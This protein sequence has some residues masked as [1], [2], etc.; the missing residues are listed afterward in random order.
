MKTILFILFLILGCKKQDTTYYSTINTDI[1]SYIQKFESI[2]I[3]QNTNYDLSTIDIALDDLPQATDSTVGTCTYSWPRQIKIKKSFWF[4]HYI[5]DTER[6]NLILHELG[7]CLLNRYSHIDSY[8]GSIPKSIMFPSVL[9]KDV[10]KNNISYYINEL[11][12]THENALMNPNIDYRE[13]LIND[14]FT[15]E[16]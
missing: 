9:N 14:K 5:S 1:N 12:H 13:P 3:S 2:Q 10:F 16:N 4:S 8:T 11:F 7:H 15:I 6:F